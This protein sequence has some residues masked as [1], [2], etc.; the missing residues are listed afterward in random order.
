[1]SFTSPSMEGETEGIG[2]TAT[3]HWLFE[4]QIVGYTCSNSTIVGCM[5]GDGGEG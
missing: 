1:M 4:E 3:N 5:I 2:I